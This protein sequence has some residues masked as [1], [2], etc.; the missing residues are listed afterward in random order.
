MSDL[1]PYPVVPTFIPANRSIDKSS[2]DISIQIFVRKVQS[3]WGSYKKAN[4]LEII[5]INYKYQKHKP[6]CVHK[7]GA[8]SIQNRLRKVQSK[9]GRYDGEIGRAWSAGPHK[10]WSQSLMSHFCYL[11]A[12]T[13]AISRKWLPGNWKENSYMVICLV[14]MYNRIIG[15]GCKHAKLWMSMT[16]LSSV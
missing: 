5:G 4:Y 3:K 14:R 13:S 12:R 8:I 6:V 10:P 16:A 7:S 9:W 2:R 15:Y 1:T 11:G